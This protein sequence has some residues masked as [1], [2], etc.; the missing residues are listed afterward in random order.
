[1]PFVWGFVPTVQEVPKTTLRLSNSLA[2]L[3]ELSKAVV[4]M[5]LVYY[6]KKI[7]NDIR[8]RKRPREQGPGE[9]Q[10]QAFSC[11]L[12][13]SC[14]DSAYFSQQWCVA[15]YTDYCQPRKFTKALKSKVFIGHWSS[16]HS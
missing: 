16:R 2:G 8:N 14:A 7:Q 11:S 15:I 13:L 1:M 10:A 6:S 4:L 3:T 9:F 5:V 12:L